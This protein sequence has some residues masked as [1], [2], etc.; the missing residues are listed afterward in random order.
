MNEI[1]MF[2]GGNLGMGL[3]SVDDQVSLSR[4]FFFS[5]VGSLACCLISLIPKEFMCACTSI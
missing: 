4:T 5:L 2:V 1:Y 3:V